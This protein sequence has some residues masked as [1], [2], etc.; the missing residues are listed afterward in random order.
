VQP[1]IKVVGCSSYVVMG[2]LISPDIQ[3]LEILLR[4][5]IL[6]DKAGWLGRRISHEG[7]SLTYHILVVGE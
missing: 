6:F 1:K 7:A 2:Y 4:R 5:A 3:A